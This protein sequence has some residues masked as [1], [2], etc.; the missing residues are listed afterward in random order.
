MIRRLVPSDLKEAIFP[1][2]LDYTC[3]TTVIT[4]TFGGCFDDQGKGVFSQFS[5]L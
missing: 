1:L 5:F 3:V 2:S 4:S